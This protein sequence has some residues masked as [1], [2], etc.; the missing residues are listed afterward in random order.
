[1]SF[2]AFQKLWRVAGI[3]HTHVNG[4]RNKFCETDESV[5][6]SARACLTRVPLRVLVATVKVPSGSRSMLVTSS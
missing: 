5:V 4:L 3:D 1:M 6:A 2:V